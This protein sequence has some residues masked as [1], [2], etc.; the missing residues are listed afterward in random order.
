MNC[1]PITLLACVCSVFLLTGPVEAQMSAVTQS[2]LS[3]ATM[4]LF[5]NNTACAA[6]ASVRMLD[7]TEKETMSLPMSF[8]MLDHKIRLELDM[9]ELKSK[10]ITQEMI[11]SFK[12][13][14]MEKM[15]NIVRPD[16]K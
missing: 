12:Q 16:K 2:G 4:K 3:A 11:A 6:K 9:N 15:I 13:M 14:R 1:S 5:G 8:S 10:E 7:R